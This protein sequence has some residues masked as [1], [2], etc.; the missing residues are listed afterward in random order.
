MFNKLIKNNQS[1]EYYGYIEGWVSIIGNIF[2]FGVKFIFG[3]ILKSISLIAEAFHSLSDVLTSL[4]VVISFKL[5]KKPADE[6]H[7]FGH[8]RIEKI[9]TLII[10]FLLIFAGID[11]AKISITRIIHPHIINPN[12]FVILFMFFSFFFKEWMTRFS[13][14][15]GKKI[16]SGI[17]IA[18]GWH[19]RL[20]GIASLIV[21]FGLIFIKKGI[22]FLDGI[23]GVIV[24]CF[25][26]WVSFDLIRK[27]SS[28]LIG[29]APDEEIIKEIDKII[30]S[31]PEIISSHDLRVHDYGNKKIISLHIEVEKNL[32][33][34]QAHEIAFSLQNK[35]KEKIENSEVSVHVDPS[36][37]KED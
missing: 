34:K 1:R 27:T 6:K 25:I 3:V 2:L 15:L 28:S 22:Y 16:N 17:L 30:S 9:A 13:F 4:V 5:S 33:L 7:P 36:G 10:A 11:L 12:I 21:G 23:L 31:T 26:L 14:F 35:S 24:V 18:D 32:S 20:D 29:E 19:H 8:G 37:E